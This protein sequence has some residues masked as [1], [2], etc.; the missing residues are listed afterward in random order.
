MSPTVNLQSPDGFG[1]T[2]K[3]FPNLLFLNCIT[4]GDIGQGNQ[5]SKRWV[6]KPYHSETYYLHRW[7]VN[8]K[9]REQLYPQNIPHS[10]QRGVHGSTV[11]LSK[12]L[13]SCEQW[14]IASPCCT[15]CTIP[16]PTFAEDLSFSFPQ[17]WQYN[18]YGLAFQQS[19]EIEYNELTSESLVLFGRHM[20]VVNA[21][22][23][24]VYILLCSDHS[25]SYLL[26]ANSMHS[27]ADC[28]QIRQP[29]FNHRRSPGNHPL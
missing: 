12:V 4:T 2:I 21:I 24:A 13:V 6:F 19:A 3:R 15:F 22:V 20:R 5:I 26:I 16:R 9:L 23:I 10:G 17:L 11:H 1:E 28:F 29:A 27:Y 25:F 8:W 7:A 14:H 18:H